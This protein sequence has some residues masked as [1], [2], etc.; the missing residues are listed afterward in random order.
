MARTE[1]K[2]E[3][4]LQNLK[5]VLG[6]ING[7]DPYWTE[8]KHVKRVPFVP[9]QFEATEKP[10]LLIVVTGQPEEIT[11]LLG[12]QDKRSMKVGIVGVIDRTA[13]DEGT[14]V[15]RFMKDVGIRIML[16]PK[17]GGYASMTFRRS[18]TDFSNLFQDLG[19]FEMVFDIEYHC[20]G[21][22]E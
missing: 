9:N 20:D 17:R 22:L 5:T 13:S 12:Y 19:M 10:G 4:I 8:V 3:L 15:N 1:S 11:N 7:V 14:L 21:R 2:R 18:Q 16:D 6:G